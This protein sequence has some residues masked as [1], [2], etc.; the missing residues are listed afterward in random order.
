[1]TASEGKK[2][3]HEDDDDDDDDGRDKEEPPEDGDE[4][5]EDS[6][7]EEKGPEEPEPNKDLDKTTDGKQKRPP[8]TVLPK[9]KPKAK[10]I[11][12]IPTFIS[13]FGDRTVPEGSLVRLDAVVKS[14]SD[15]TAEWRK[16]DEIINLEDFSHFTVISEGNLYSLLISDTSENDSGVYT[17]LLTNIT[18]T[19][20][21][22]AKIEISGKRLFGIS[23]FKR[24]TV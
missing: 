15:V 9:P 19:A 1:M 20:T 7:P 5:P 21:C 16:N 4:G 6:R 22:S 18:G 8:P 13:S 24:E 23:S 11:G 17:C 3:D 14:E 10:D 2:S 12:E